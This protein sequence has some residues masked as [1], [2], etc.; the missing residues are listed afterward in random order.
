M[1]QQDIIAYL[2]FVNST[3]G[4]ELNRDENFK[5]FSSVEIQQQLV[6]VIGPLINPIFT[7]ICPEDM[8]FSAYATGFMHGRDFQKRQES[9][10]SLENLYNK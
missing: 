10:E 6:S 5:L 2:E 4:K 7:I 3:K 8:V 1:K 9:K